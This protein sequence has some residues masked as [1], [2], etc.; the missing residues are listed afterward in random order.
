MERLK[1]EDPEGFEHKM[2]KMERDRIQVPS[3]T[4]ERRMRHMCRVT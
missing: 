4:L 2:Q 1:T 3:L